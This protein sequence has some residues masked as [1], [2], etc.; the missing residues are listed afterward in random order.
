MLGQSAGSF[1][2]FFGGEPPRVGDPVKGLESSENIDE[3]GREAT[4]GLG[5]APGIGVQSPEKSGLA[6]PMDLQKGGI[7]EPRTGGLE[8]GEQTRGLGDLG[9]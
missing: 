4:I 1:G 6:G 2:C 9:R 3:R 7:V 5:P 8:G